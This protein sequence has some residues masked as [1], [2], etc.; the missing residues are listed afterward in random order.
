MEF[1]LSFLPRRRTAQ[2]KS[3]TLIPSPKRITNNT[4]LYSLQPLHLD[5]TDI[6]LVLICL[7]L[8]L[9]HEGLSVFAMDLGETRISQDKLRPCSRQYRE[10]IPCTP[11]VLQLRVTRTCQTGAWANCSSKLCFKIPSASINDT[12]LGATWPVYRS[13]QQW[14][15]LRHP[16]CIWSWRKNI[17]KR[18]GGYLDDLGLK[19]LSSW[20]VLPVLQASCFDGRSGCSQRMT[21]QQHLPAKSPCVST[22]PLT[23]F[24]GVHKGIETSTRLLEMEQCPYMRAWH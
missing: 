22:S 7:C 9:S 21:L 15:V 1:T 17:A 18:L 5:F 8:A 16:M 24:P 14:E 10:K 2:I 20:K 4:Q 23:R 19:S 3:L 13:C 12:I 11:Q 6:H